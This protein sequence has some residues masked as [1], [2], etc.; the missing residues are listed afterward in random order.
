SVANGIITG[1]AKGETDVYAEYQG[2]YDYVTVSVINSITNLSI[3]VENKTMVKGSSQ[4]V[5]V[6]ARL[7]SGAYEDVTKDCDLSISNYYFLEFNYDFDEEGNIGINALD[8][9]KAK[10]TARYGSKR[11]ILNIRIIQAELQ[12]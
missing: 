8:R 12:N 1:V 10:I 9:G 11:A 6:L 3:Q 7:S 4:K 2:S 5:T